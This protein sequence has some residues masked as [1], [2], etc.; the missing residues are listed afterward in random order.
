MVGNEIELLPGMQRLDVAGDDVGEF[1]DD[2][3]FVVIDQL[4]DPGGRT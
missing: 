4:L 2:I 3:A 1:A